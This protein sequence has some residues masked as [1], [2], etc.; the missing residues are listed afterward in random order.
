MGYVIRKISPDKLVTKIT[1]TR[2]NATLKPRWLAVKGVDSAGNIYISDGA[3]RCIKKLASDGTVTVLAGLC[4]KREFKPVYIQGTISKAELMSPE[5]ILLNK[6]GEIVF[7]DLRLNRIIT[8]AGN[9][10]STLAGNSVIQPNNV[11]MGGRSQEGYKDGPALTA[12]FNFPQ[13]VQIE[14][15]S[16]QNI[17]IIDGGNDC[18]RK[19]SADGIVSTI[20]KK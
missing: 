11:N 3:A 20:A 12:L 2:D 15:D 14:I 1:N 17:Y 6:K 7:A 4:N 8:I 16:K 18:I 13:G 9:K 10:V 5:D 19:L